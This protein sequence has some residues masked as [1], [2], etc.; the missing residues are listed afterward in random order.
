MPSPGGKINTTFL[1]AGAVGLE[2]VRLPARPS[3][4]VRERDG[5]VTVGVSRPIMLQ[6]E[7]GAVEIDGS[8]IEDRP[9]SAEPTAQR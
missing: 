7:R 6:R 5:D 3:R 2:R 1:A 4:L 8:L 9:A